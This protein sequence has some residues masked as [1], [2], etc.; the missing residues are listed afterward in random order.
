M[1]KL[2]LTATLLLAGALGAMAQL[3]AADAFTSAPQNIFPLLDRNTR[4]DMV[5]YVKSGLSTPSQNSLQ[6]RSAIT[7][8]SP[9]SLTVK[10]SD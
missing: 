3:T 9:E 8:I 4:L 1:K 6:G 10:M 2:L 7:E 5:D